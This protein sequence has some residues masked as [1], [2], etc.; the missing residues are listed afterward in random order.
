MKKDFNS[1]WQTYGTLGI[2]VL[3]TALLGILS[4]EYFLTSNNLVQVVLQS[5]IT[6][7]I[8]CGEFFAILI[9]GIDLSVGSIIALTGMITAKMMASGIPVSIAVLVGGILCGALLGAINGSLV[10][11]TGLHPFIITLGTQAIYR[12]I[13]LI[14]S[15][16]RPVFGFPKSFTS[17]LAGW[18]WK[19]PIPIIIAL[20]VAV[21]LTFVTT[22]TKLG[23]NIYAL[24]GN[25][26]SA[27]FSGINIKIHTLIVFII[28]GVCSGIAGVVMTARLGAAEPL[29]GVGFETF[30]IASAIIGGTSFFGGK[31]KIFG[32]VMG[33]L[34][35]GV[36]NNGLNILNVETYYQQ[37]VM[38][39]LIIGAVTLD[40]LFSKK[41]G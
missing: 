26:Q 12:G 11:A 7:L 30:A 25:S 27:W 17:G 28:S 13:T 31:G 37:I 36:I 34:I 18:L 15:N 40:K 35:I 39:A 2:F 1:I 4:P 9:A 32:V 22:K 33:G 19:I 41:K 5:S 24:G 29:A 6:I 8:A 16:A 23:R 14:I 10:N 21:I 38:G 20:M 3:I